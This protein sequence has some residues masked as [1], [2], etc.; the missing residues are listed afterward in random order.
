MLTDR[1]GVVA[2]AIIIDRPGAVA[3]AIV[4][5][6][7]GAVAEAIVTDRP[8]VVAE[9]GLLAGIGAALGKPLPPWPGLLIS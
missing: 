2:V 3:E 8:G 1:P 4:T 7:P 9:S 5:D 6:R